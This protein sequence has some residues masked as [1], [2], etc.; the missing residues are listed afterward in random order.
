MAEV[1]HWGGLSDNIPSASGATASAEAGTGNEG[2]QTPGRKE[3][4]TPRVMGEKAQIAD[5]L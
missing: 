1:A 4:P 5:R 3:A 2:A